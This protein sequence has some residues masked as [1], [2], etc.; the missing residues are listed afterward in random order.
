MST[1][2]YLTQLEALLM[3]KATA[4]VAIKILKEKRKIELKPHF[5]KPDELATAPPRPEPKTDA[6]LFAIKNNLWPEAK[7]L[8]QS[9]EVGWEKASE[10]LGIDIACKHLAR[11]SSSEESRQ[12]MVPKTPTAR[13]HWL[14][15]SCMARKR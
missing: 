11:P 2:E 8:L 15:L 5:S 7:E 13:S 4:S 3:A 10:F 1:D 12:S 14:S 9:E 6:Q